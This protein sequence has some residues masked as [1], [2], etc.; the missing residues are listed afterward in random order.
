MEKDTQETI[1]KLKS[2]KRI[3]WFQYFF[4]KSTLFPTVVHFVI[5]YIPHGFTHWSMYW[6]KESVSHGLYFR[7]GWE[8]SEQI[9]NTNKLTALSL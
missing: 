2:V 8:I 7:L 9:K 5:V 4:K 6:K 1:N 3:V